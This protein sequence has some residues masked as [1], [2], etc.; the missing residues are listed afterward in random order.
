MRPSLTRPSFL[1]AI[2]SYLRQTTSKIKAHLHTVFTKARVTRL[3]QPLLWPEGLS[4]AGH[5]EA[6][7]WGMCPLA[8][9]SKKRRCFKNDSEKEVQRDRNTWKGAQPGLEKKQKATRNLISQIDDPE[10]M[11]ELPTLPP[12]RDGEGSRA[13]QVGVNLETVKWG[14]VAR[15]RALALQLWGPGACP[16]HQT[17]DSHINIH[18]PID[19]VSPIVENPSQW[20]S[21]NSMNMYVHTSLLALATFVIKKKKTSTI[22]CTYTMDFS[23]AVFWKME[24]ISVTTQEWSLE[25][26]LHYRVKKGGGGKCMNN[27]VDITQ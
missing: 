17:G 20:Y 18:F 10:K 11:P 24:N 21:D 7:S 25:Y 5:G 27:S 6:F 4:V 16:Q 23:D 8:C 22:K 15:D 9:S 2:L 1:T 26:N 14:W 19:T 12:G 3:P 13:L